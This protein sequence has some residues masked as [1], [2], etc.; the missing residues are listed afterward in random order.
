MLVFTR[1]L[2]TNLGI[3]DTFGSRKLGQ[4]RVNGSWRKRVSKT[5]HKV[6]RGKRL[7]DEFF[8]RPINIY[9][10][11]Y[12]YRDTKVPGH[13]IARK[14]SVFGMFIASTVYL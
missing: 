1:F 6:I 3:Q 2:P 7:V 14:G 13:V 5:F 9:I 8:S 12:M 10:Y 4:Q 11:I